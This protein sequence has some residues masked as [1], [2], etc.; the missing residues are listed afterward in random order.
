MEGSAIAPPPQVQRQGYLILTMVM[1]IAGSF[2]SMAAFAHGSYRVGPLI[3]EMKVK[4]ATKGTTELAVS[5]ISSAPL[6]HPGHAIA[7]THTGFLGFEGTVTGV[8]VADPALLAVKELADPKA[9]A[10]EIKKDGRSAAKKFGLRVGLV[11]LGG[12]AAG[13]FAV[14]LIGMRTRRIFQGAIAGVIV[15]AI[16]GVLAW[17]TYDIDKFKTVHFTSGSAIARTVHR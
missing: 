2:I 13:G 5:P 1:G 14:A 17:Q 10:D 9:L 3:V 16:L 4:P 15:V 8:Y 7:D 12:G 6:I 11:V